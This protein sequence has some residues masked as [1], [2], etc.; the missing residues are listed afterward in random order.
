M[1]ETINADKVKVCRA[2]LEIT[3]HNRKVTASKLRG[4]MGYFF[5]E[6][7]EFHHHGE[8]AYKYPLIQ[9][10]RINGK[11]LILGLNE[12]APILTQKIAQLDRIIIP[13]QTI[14]VRAVDIQNDNH[15]IRYEQ[16]QYS[17]ATPWI[18]LN[19]HN[20]RVFN[21]SKKDEQKNLLQRV[22]VGNILSALKGLGIRTKE[23]I[24]VSINEYRPVHVKAHGNS[25]E[26]FNGQ[27]EA[28][29]CLP[30][31]IGLGKS[32]SKGFGA[33]KPVFKNQAANTQSAK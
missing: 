24:I 9:Y 1:A 32:V 16:Q 11:L 28:N 26:A 22:L 17:F 2:F 12:Y 8:N 31:F 5:L 14:E 29:I 7:E 18:A 13:K 15:Y 4:F 21:Q 25:F 6:D 30:E 10:K 20:Y 3:E 27:F 23:R 33:I 19:E